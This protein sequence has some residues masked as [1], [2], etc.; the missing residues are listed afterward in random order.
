MS[1][2]SYWPSR[3]PIEEDGGTNLYGMVGNAAVDQIDGL[4]LLKWKKRKTEWLIRPSNGPLTP[5]VRPEGGIRYSTPGRGALAVTYPHVE[6][7][8]PCKENKKI[9]GA[10]CWFL[11]EA[12]M[13][14]GSTVTL[15][16]DA[17]YRRKGIDPAWVKRAEK[18]HVKDF[19]EWG[20]NVAKALAQKTETA[21][22]K[23]AYA[24]KSEFEAAALSAFRVVLQKSANEALDQTIAK[25]DDRGKHNH[26]NENR[27]P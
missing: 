19:D 17:S 18:D 25:W 20:K 13:K 23:I 26:A 9:G 22:K 16:D 11:K 14:Y 15:Y 3:D 5:P 8:F 2:V 4:G 27:R 24:T 1:R 7:S 10:K 21:Q 12:S 6:G